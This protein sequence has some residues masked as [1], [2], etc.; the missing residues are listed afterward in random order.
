MEMR[1]AEEFTSVEGEG[2]RA[3]TPQHFIRLAGCQIGTCPIRT[4]CDT[5]YSYRYSKSIEELAMSARDAVGASGWVCITGGEPMDQRREIPKLVDEMHR[6]GLKVALQTSGVR[7]VFF[8]VDWLVVSPKCA[9]GDLQQ[10]TGN[11]LKLVWTGLQQDYG[12]LRAFY[13]LTHF[14]HYFIQ[15][16][17]N[18]DGTHN[19]VEVSD[20]C[21]NA[22]KAGCGPWRVS[23]QSHK[24]LGVK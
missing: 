22:N 23:A 3:G 1:V 8:E 14:T 21:L 10:S 6:L 16:L 18:T 13:Q 5:D 15:P 11:E 4:L 17:W 7:D 20:V 2:H 9:V 24:L 19:G 12:T